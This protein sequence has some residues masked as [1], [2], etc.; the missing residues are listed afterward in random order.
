MSSV[1]DVA[2]GGGAVSGCTLLQSIDNDV[3]LHCCESWDAVLNFKV[4][5]CAS[6]SEPFPF[7][8]VPNSFTE[9]NLLT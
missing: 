1:S 6:K 8:T 3:A 7:G 9:C 2:A 5:Q 4:L